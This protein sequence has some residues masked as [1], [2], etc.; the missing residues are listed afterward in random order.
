[1]EFIQ[2]SVRIEASSQH[3]VEDPQDGTIGS[4]RSLYQV[5]NDSETANVR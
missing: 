3:H 5:C 4:E 2:K 1:M